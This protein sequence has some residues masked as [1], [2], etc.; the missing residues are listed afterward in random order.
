MLRN[1]DPILSPECLQI[2]RAMGHGDDLVI[3]DSNFPATTCA[4]RL[5]RMDG[6]DGPRALEAI[7]KLFPVDDFVKDPILRIEVVDNPS[8]LPPVCQEYQTIVD[9]HADNKAKIQPIDRFAFYD[10]SKAAFAVIA[11]GELRL[12]GC[13]I[14]K[15]GVIRPA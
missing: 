12:Y 15:K 11:T 13:L 2:L 10:R 7:L 6:I 5:I 8:F 1:I 4:K 14:L 9:K 3:A